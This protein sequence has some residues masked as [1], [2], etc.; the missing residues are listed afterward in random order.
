VFMIVSARAH[1]Y[2][3]DRLVRAITRLG[4]R[5]D[6]R[7]VLVIAVA[8]PE[9]EQVLH[10]GPLFQAY[11]VVAEELAGNA[12]QRGVAVEPGHREAGA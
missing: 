2:R 6:G 4:H 5:F 10:P 3:R 7:E 8:I 9:E 11:R 1:G 12:D